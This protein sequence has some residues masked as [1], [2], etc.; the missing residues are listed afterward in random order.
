AIHAGEH[1]PP[2]EYIPIATPIHVAASYLY[3][4][5]EQLYAV[6]MGERQGYVYTRY[7]N[8][9]VGAME[10]AVADLE[11]TEAALGFTSGLAA[12]YAAFVGAGLGAGD[13]VVA[14][15]ALYGSV[16]P[17]LN[18]LLRRFDVETTFVDITDLEAVEGAIAQVKPRLV[19]FEMV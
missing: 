15:R 7:G 3:P 11:G 12:N 9:T 8:P 13:R 10:T 4:D 6:T 17:L 16:F 2:G 5:L 19:H 18:R 14:W 1:A